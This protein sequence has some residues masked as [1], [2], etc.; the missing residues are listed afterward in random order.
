MFFIADISGSCTYKCR[1]MSDLKPTP[2]DDD[3]ALSNQD[4]AISEDDENEN[5]SDME[6]VTGSER[7]AASETG[8]E[9]PSASDKSSQRLSR[10]AS[11]TPT[12]TRSTR[13]QNN[14]KFVA[15]QKSFMAKVQAAT[16]GAELGMGRP[17]TPG[18]RKRDTSAPTTPPTKRRRSGRT[19][20]NGQVRRI[21]SHL[22]SYYCL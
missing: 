17:E 10:S 5:L 4:A 12:N 14:P 6:S 13:S 8:S 16:S 3:S 1:K 21:Q 19:D 2:L 11:N 7:D 18:K 15:K 9:T 22:Q 20:N